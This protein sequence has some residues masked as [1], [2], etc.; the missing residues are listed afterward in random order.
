MKQR[1]P[2]ANTGGPANNSRIPEKPRKSNEKR[3]ILAQSSM[4]E[5]SVPLHQITTFI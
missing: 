2:W 4:V 1:R 3:K 5:L